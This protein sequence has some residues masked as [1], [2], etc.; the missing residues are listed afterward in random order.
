MHRIYS[1]R[2]PL[3]HMCHIAPSKLCSTTSS[4]GVT[5]KTFT[6][7]ASHMILTTC[8]SGGLFSLSQLTPLKRIS[9]SP[10][11]FETRSGKGGFS[12]TGLYSPELSRGGIGVRPLMCRQGTCGAPEFSRHPAGRVATA[13]VRQR[14]LVFS[15]GYRGLAQ[16]PWCAV[17]VSYLL[18]IWL[19]T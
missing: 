3:S 16:C 5:C 19:E 13:A 15:S 10:L 11:P 8:G 18:M 9:L 14:P 7:P 2:T 6:Q 17:S 4:Y 12:T 1:S